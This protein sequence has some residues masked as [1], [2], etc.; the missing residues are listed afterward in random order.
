MVPFA[1]DLGQRE[2]KLRGEGSRTASLWEFSVLAALV[3]AAWSC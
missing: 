2:D 1:V 3:T